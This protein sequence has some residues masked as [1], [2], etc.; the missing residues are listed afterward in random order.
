MRFRFCH[1]S[2]RCLDRTLRLCVLPEYSLEPSVV[3]LPATN[4]EI[5][6]IR[7]AEFVMFTIL[8]GLPKEEARQNGHHFNNAVSC[9]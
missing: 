1:A 8:F 3:P 7:V 6:E 4:R 9:F 5:T 2:G